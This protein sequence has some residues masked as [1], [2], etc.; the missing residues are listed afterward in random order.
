MKYLL[1]T[2]A[3]I[4]VF[5][6]TA[7][8]LRDRRLVR[9][10]IWGVILPLCLFNA[11]SINFFSHE[12]YR[13]TSRGMEVSIIYI[14]AVTLLFVFS[15]LRGPLKLM[16]EFGSRIYFV[17]FLLN[18]PSLFNAPNLLFSFFE[19]WKMIMVYLVFLA[20]YY[21]MDFNRGNADPILYGV[22]FLVLVNFLDVLFQH[23][24]QGIYRARGVFPHQNSMAMYMTIAGLLF[25]SRFINRNDSANGLIFLAAL[26]MASV[27]VVA[28]Y[29]RGAIVC[30]PLGGLLTLVASMCGR[31]SM[32]KIRKLLL[33]VPLIVAGLI[34]FT[35][36]IVKRFQT[37]PEES[38]NTR[39]N[40]AVAALNMMRDKPFI[41]VGINNWGVVINPPYTYSKHRSW[42]KGHTDEFRD[43][44]VE[45]VYLLVGAECGIPCLFLL[46]CWFGYYWLSTLFLMKKL[47]RTDSY[48]LPAGLFGALTAI[49]LQSAL[50]WVLKQ[51]INLIW[52]VTVFAIISYLNRHHKDLVAAGSDAPAG[53]AAAAPQ[54]PLAE[55]T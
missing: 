26:A 11:M 38:G 40:L 8:L 14:A 9:W 18:I 32:G 3:V 33:F 51:Q 21:Y 46:L 10:G 36:G 34:L 25:F 28:S 45:T 13:G 31:W 16:P 4:G 30:Y 47:R 48:Y 17:Y 23:F 37:A 50:E 19:L 35:P 52:L 22:A 15:I 7:I 39:K 20:V 6:A 42:E 1:F 29:S 5:P 44:I 53:T 43:G 49:F 12:S 41:G 27:A 24:F 54:T 55:T 2:V